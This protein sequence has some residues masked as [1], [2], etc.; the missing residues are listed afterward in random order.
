MVWVWSDDLASR[1]LARGDSLDAKIRSWIEQPVALKIPDRDSDDTIAKVLGIEN[2][3]LVL[4]VS[5]PTMARD[6]HVCPCGDWPRPGSA[7]ADVGHV[8]TNA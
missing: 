7:P 5:E 3:G 6:E 2:L 1:L 8:V 4:A